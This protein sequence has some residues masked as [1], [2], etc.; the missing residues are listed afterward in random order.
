MVV[1]FGH[2]AGRS[3]PEAVFTARP[4]WPAGGEVLSLADLSSRVSQ[5]VLARPQRPVFHSLL[6]L[7]GGS[8]EVT[9]DFTGHHLRPGTWLWVRPSQVIQWGDLTQAEGMLVL[10]QPEELDPGTAALVQPVP[11]G[12]VVLPASE[13]DRRALDLAA[14]HLAREYSAFGELPP[15]VHTVLLRHLLAVLVLRL[16]HAA[17]GRSGTTPD[18]GGAYVRFRDAVEEHFPRTRHVED[19][20]RLLGYSPRTL[21]RATRE[22]A[23]IGAKAFVDQRVVLEAKRQL[24]HTDR[25][26]SQIAAQLGFSSATNFG[27]FFAQHTGTP[28]GGFRAAVRSGRGATSPPPDTAR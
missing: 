24:A 14:L 5:D 19:Y 4:D 28:P 11:H 23:G 8:L 21:T 6:A 12:P 9:V 7:T 2:G 1:E 20:A 18:P 25:S 26:A 10:F 3:I 22:V 13:G 16:V 15:Q 17:A 27:K